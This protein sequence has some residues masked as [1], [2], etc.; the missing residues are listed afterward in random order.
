[1][2][3]HLGEFEQL[4]LM[5]MLQLEDNAYGVTI[6][7][8]IEGRTCRG[9]SMGGLY[10]TLERM[11]RKGLVSSRQGSPTPSRGGRAKKFWAPTR[12]GA[13]AL[14]SSLAALRSMAEG[15]ADKVQ[16]P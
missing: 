1:M 11:A 12:A 8:E 6:A 16:A 13:T 4:V 10:T 14:E 2:S 7:R 5:A 15:L 9:V 3:R